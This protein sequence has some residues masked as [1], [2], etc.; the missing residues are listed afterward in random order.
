MERLNK[1]SF[2]WLSLKYKNMTL[3]IHSQESVATDYG[4]F[5]YKL[6][7]TVYKTEVTIGFFFFRF[8]LEFIKK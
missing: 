7:K 4:Q 5:L 2:Q 1:L 8:I 3:G 6:N